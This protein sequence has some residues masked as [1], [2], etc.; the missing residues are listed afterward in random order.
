[1]ITIPDGYKPAGGHNEGQGT[2]GIRYQI[3]ASG[4]SLSFG[5]CLSLK[6]GSKV[7]TFSTGNYLRINMSWITND[8]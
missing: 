4:S 2:G 1:M 5:F 6:D 3:V 8:V 7:D